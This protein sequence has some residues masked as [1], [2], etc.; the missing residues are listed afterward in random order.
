[1]RDGNGYAC[2]R[3]HGHSFFDFYGCVAF[4]AVASLP[5]KP[6][7]GPVQRRNGF[8]LLPAKGQFC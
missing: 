6:E 5:A 8:A 4:P 3:L 1:M 7:Y 2:H